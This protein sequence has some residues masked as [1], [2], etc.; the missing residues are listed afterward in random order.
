MKDIKI[1]K[2]ML[3]HKDLVIRKFYGD[4]IPHFL[5]SD[6]KRK[7]NNIFY[8]RALNDLILVEDRLIEVGTHYLNYYERIAKIYIKD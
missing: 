5:V 1:E 4:K 2:K 8:E 7:K 6:G 3:Y